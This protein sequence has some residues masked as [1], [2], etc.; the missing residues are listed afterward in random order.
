MTTNNAPR[1]EP[2][3]VTIDD[4]PTHFRDGTPIDEWRR[5]AIAE[6]ANLRIR[7]QREERARAQS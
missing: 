3:P 2:R 5:R 1:I 4:V 7:A 6:G